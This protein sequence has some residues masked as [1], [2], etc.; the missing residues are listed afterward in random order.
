MREETSV[1]MG[2]CPDRPKGHRGGGQLCGV[3]CG[4]S[5]FTEKLSVE[6]RHAARG[7]G[8]EARVACRS[9]A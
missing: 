7:P 8:R 9:A 3:R 4:E 5:G 6:S 2:R 1:E